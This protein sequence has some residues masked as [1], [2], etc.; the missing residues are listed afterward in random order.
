MDFSK[1]KSI[2]D[3]NTT[4]KVKIGNA[5]G[6]ISDFIF[7]LDGLYYT[8]DE[9]IKNGIQSNMRIGEIYG[10]Y[11]TSY[12]N[13]ENFLFFYFYIIFEADI[14]DNITKLTYLQN[15][16][17][18][19]D[20]F[21]T[22][23]DPL[24][25]SIIDDYYKYLKRENFFNTFSIN[26]FQTKYLEWKHM[27]VRKNE[28]E[29]KYYSKI[30][31][32][33]RILSNFH[34]TL[35]SEIYYSDVIQKYIIEFPDSN[36]LDIYDIFNMC[37][38]TRK[39]PHIACMGPRGETFGN[40]INVETDNWYKVFTGEDFTDLPLIKLFDKNI[41]EKLENTIQ[42]IVYI[43]T[44]DNINDQVLTKYNVVTLF[45]NEYEISIEV[46]TPL[47]TIEKN[48]IIKIINEALPFSIKKV[49][50]RKIV[51]SVDFYPT[52]QVEGL[53]IDVLVLLDIVFTF[54][55]FNTYIYCPSFI[56]SVADT[57]RFKLYST[58]VTSIKVGTEKRSMNTECSCNVVQQKTRE[59]TLVYIM[60]QGTKIETFLNS[61]CNYITINFTAKDENSVTSF[62]EVLSRLFWMLKYGTVQICRDNKT[63]LTY[64]DERLD[65]GELIKNHIRNFYTS[66]VSEMAKIDYE[67]SSTKIGSKEDYEE[68][69]ERIEGISEK[70]ENDLNRLKRYAPDLFVA[71]YASII[72]ST[73]RPKIIEESE[74]NS[75]KSHGYEVYVYPKETIFPHYYFIRSNDTYVHFALKEN[76]LSNK[77]KYEYIPYFSSKPPKQDGNIYS[78]YNGLPKKPSKA[79]DNITKK[80]KPVKEGRM[81]YLSNR[82]VTFLREC[83]EIYQNENFVR[84]G[85]TRN[86]ENNKNS[87]IH[88]VLFGI[89][90][91]QY[92]ASQNKSDYVSN[93]RKEILSHDKVNLN[94]LKQENYEIDE[95]RLKEI[96]EEGDSYF[97]SKFYYRLFEEYFN[98]NIFIFT[99]SYN[100]TFSIEIP[101]S[102][103]FH[104]RTN[105][106]RKTILLYRNPGKFTTYET[107]CSIGTTKTI[108]R[109]MFGTK[110]GSYCFET[111]LNINS[112]VTFSFEKTT[113]IN[114][115]NSINYETFLGTKAISQYIDRYGKL[116][117][118][119]FNTKDGNI[120]LIVQPS[121]PL[122]LPLSKPVS[123]NYK[124]LLHLIVETPTNYDIRENLVYGVWY[125]I[126]DIVE[127]IYIPIIPTHIHEF[128]IANY[129]PEKVRI[130][131]LINLE[132]RTTKKSIISKIDET[133]RKLSFINQIIKYVYR[134]IINENPHID[135]MQLYE[136][137]IRNYFVIK[138]TSYDFTNL[139]RL[140]PFGTID[141]IMKDFETQIPTFIKDGK[142]IMYNRKFAEGIAY[143]VLE[144]TKNHEG[145]IFAPINRIVNYYSRETDFIQFR[146][147][148]IFKSLSEFSEWLEK[149]Y[150]NN[151]YYDKPTFDLMKF[152][153]PKIYGNRKEGYFIVQNCN[154]DTLDYSNNVNVPG[155]ETSLSVCVNWSNRGINTGFHTRPFVDIRDSI[156]PYV[157]KRIGTNGKLIVVGKYMNDTGNE[158]RN[159]ELASSTN[160]Q[161]IIHF[162]D[163]QDRG[164]YAALLSLNENI[165]NETRC[166]QCTIHEIEEE[167]TEETDVLE[168]D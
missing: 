41:K 147:T 93:F 19:L 85:F 142:F 154:Y 121:Q 125:Q 83:S 130:N 158:R 103:I 141:D 44:K 132:N 76:T 38:T 95:E 100:N 123:I 22:V 144:Y 69:N 74:V 70:E 30:I 11:V 159:W 2:F 155:I 135:S 98:I 124:N 31:E 82:L 139:R 80:N 108:Q 65:G 5:H 59:N 13:A 21:F 73:K 55:C 78:Y 84:R 105:K 37:K 79:V 47:K 163:G 152:I 150:S 26:D 12:K 110:M 112:E 60:D 4:T 18:R 29:K 58:A 91:P 10:K 8:I 53:K 131:P 56:K 72:K 137:F 28:E 81:A 43:G 162:T 16:K 48:S 61:D 36:I 27:I 40:K 88:A 7:F 15:I 145:M 136:M 129:N 111:L 167:R 115:Y 54:D 146:E 42:F 153:E 94:V 101:K 117:S 24:K 126:Y 99:Q 168:D 90:D 102:K 120:S 35:N 6:L 165:Q 119:T 9:I 57:K 107:V 71:G 97:D 160:Y 39:V 51:G 113:R 33:E 161:E 118:L 114:V 63:S 68:E 52:E 116:R 157:E 66:F 133:R 64:I 86:E 20:N 3:N 46:K 127:G 148:L 87:F 32:S 134:L 138:D 17:Y 106:S 109:T 75:Y 67:F 14:Y 143:S 49:E 149:T 34:T 92:L 45:F 166:S 164:R 89:Q 77:D 104:I 128:G 96:I 62:L 50:E 1:Y 23:P 151:I 122:N 25:L 156:L 140:F